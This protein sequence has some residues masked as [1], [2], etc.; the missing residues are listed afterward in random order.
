MKRIA[1]A[2]ALI[3][4]GSHVMFGQAAQPVPQ[5]SGP[6]IL[7]ILPVSGNLDQAELFYHE[8][9]RNLHRAQVMYS[10]C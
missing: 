3:V 1:A 6:T 4:A 2:T 10:G 9:F 8:T 7:N 5:A